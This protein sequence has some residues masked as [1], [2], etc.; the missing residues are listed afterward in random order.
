MPFCIGAVSVAGL[1]AALYV[2][3]PNWSFPQ[4]GGWFGQTATSPVRE[5]VI[6]LVVETPENVEAMRAAVHPDRIVAEARNSFALDEGRVIAASVETAGE[7]LTAAG[8]VHRPLEILL[9]NRRP[10]SPQPASAPAV[11]LASKSPLSQAEALRL[12]NQLD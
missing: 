10:E 1:V 9:Q 3:P 4:L 7:S 8:W 12:L 6:V 5:P 11:N 2:W